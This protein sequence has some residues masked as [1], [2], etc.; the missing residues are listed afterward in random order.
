MWGGLE[1]RFANPTV[2]ISSSSSFDLGFKWV[3]SNGSSGKTSSTLLDLGWN[4]HFFADKC[5]FDLFDNNSLGTEAG[6]DASDSLFPT[7]SVIVPAML[8]PGINSSKLE[9]GPLIMF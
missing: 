7:A 8:S 1:G 2:E 5:D 9:H 4:R 3:S 6:P